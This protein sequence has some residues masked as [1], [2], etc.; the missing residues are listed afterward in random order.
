MSTQQL[1]KLA[2][3]KNSAAGTGLLAQYFSDVSFTNLVLTKTDSTIDFNWHGKTPDPT[4]RTDY[5]VRWTGQLSSVFSERYTFHMATEGKARLWINDQ[6][7]IDDWADHD[8]R[9]VSGS[10]NLVA[11]QQYSI[12]MD[13]VENINWGVAKLFWSSSSQTKQVIPQSQL[14]TPLSTSSSMANLSAA[15]LSSDQGASASIFSSTATPNQAKTDGTGSSADYELG[16]EFKSAKA[17]TISAIRY[18]KA[19]GETG[20]HIGR[21]WSS[22]G[23]LLGSVTFTNETASGWQQQQLANPLTID[24]NTTYIVSVNAKSYYAIT[25]NGLATPV[26]NGD[27][28]ASKGVFNTAPGSLPTQSWNSSNY[29]RDV[30]FV[31]TLSS[32]AGTPGSLAFSAPTFS[33]N[34][35]GIAVAAVTVTRTGGSSGAVG[36]T[37]TLAAGTATIADYNGNSI[38]VTFAD[39]DTAAKTIKIPIA[40]DTVKESNETLNLSLGSLIGGATLGSQKTATLTIIDNDSTPVVDSAPVVSFSSSSSGQTTQAAATDPSAKSQQE[41]NTG[42]TPFTFSVTLSKASTQV[43]TV[44]Y[45]INNGTAIAGSDY[46]DN[47]GV[48]TF[49]AG[50]TSKTIT[51]AVNGDTTVEQN[52]QFTVNLGT[53]SNATLG[54]I[55]QVTTTIVNDDVS[56]PSPTPTNV[57]L[58][59]LGTQSA[60]GS[61]PT[62]PTG[63]DVFSPSFTGMVSSQAP[64]ISEWTKTGKAGDTIVLTGWKFSGLTGSQAGTDTKFWVYGQSESGNGVLKEAKIVKLDGDVA[65]ITLPTG[66]PSGSEY[67]VWAQNDSGVSKPITINQTEAW[68]VGPDAATRGEV[69]SIFGRNL[70]QDGGT[71]TANVYIEDSAG[72]GYW[73]PIISANPYKIDFKVPTGLANGSY[74]VWVHNGDGGQYGWSKPVTLTVNDGLTYTGKTFNVKDFGAKGDGVTD[75]TQAIFNAITAASKSSMSTVYFPTGT[76][77]VSKPIYAHGSFGQND[78]RFQGAGKN[79]TTVKAAKN[80]SGEYMYQMQNGSNVTFADMTLD[81]NGKPLSRILMI[82]SASDI[83]L[84]N[85][86]LDGEGSG[87]MA[88]FDVHNSTRVFVKNSDVTGAQSFLGTAS[89][90]FINRSNFYGSEYGASL[91]TGFGTQMLSITNSTGQNLD[92]SDPENGKW[93][94]GRLWVDQS[95]WSNSQ[96]QYLGNNKTIDLSVAN[97]TGLDQ[98]AGEQILWESI[99]AEKV[100]S[101]TSSTAATVTFSS[102]SDAD[103]TYFLTIT[104]G[105]GIGQTRQVKSFSS[106]NK[107]VTIE[108]NWNVLPDSSSTITVN[109]LP[110]N[111]VVY[112]NQ[113]DGL[114]DYKTRFTASAG[115]QSYYGSNDLIVDRN[116]FKELRND[117]SLYSGWTENGIRPS[118]FTQVTGNK[119][120]DSLTGLGFHIDTSGGATKQ[121]YNL[122]TIVRGNSSSNVKESIGLYYSPTSGGPYS[123]MNVFEQNTL[124]AETRSVLESTTGNNVINNISL[125]NSFI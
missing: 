24:A 98:N 12:R 39:G 121:T 103:S 124:G 97:V 4:I 125:L 40:N 88:P 71:T 51:V 70:T 41:G 119:F 86:N 7:V 49:K 16:M 92:P 38:V 68:W 73:A 95:H 69:T 35:D 59:G 112:N 47:D 107:T 32:P 84:L 19:P 79:L 91:L 37:I 111:L 106:G 5:S 94:N 89:Q 58:P 116:T 13:F 105:K 61:K 50:E 23:K 15:A 33:V 81:S 22:S 42:T 56:S 74:K 113:L 96:Y 52:E 20:T 120:T 30:V 114:S 28:T 25:E 45:T 57:N 1:G 87:Q 65:S 54:T 75:D 26:K 76:F 36:A 53:P 82:R 108:G 17:G 117:I 64:V 62:L 93:V 43:V 90:V 67:I 8:L 122:G 18:Y 27:L 63:S 72:K 44:P 3:G 46:L 85:L 55:K 115:V 2:V 109:R 104:S 60:P 6:L 100:G 66:L 78:I 102:I 9:E 123:N 77:M 110:S 14:H 99:Q 80:F 83:Q 118:Y 48:L 31:P 11:G 21:I 10:V 101:V 34:E 29:F